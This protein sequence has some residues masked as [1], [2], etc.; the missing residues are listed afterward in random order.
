MLRLTVVYHIVLIIY[1]NFLPFMKLVDFK[2]LENIF[3]Y[4]DVFRQYFY[5]LYPTDSNC[6]LK[7]KIERILMHSNSGTKTDF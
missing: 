3:Q 4:C 1:R 6:E 2:I 5:L 7:S